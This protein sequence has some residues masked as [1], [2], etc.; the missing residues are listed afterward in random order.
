MMLIVLSWIYFQFTYEI[1]FSHV[2]FII[3][4]AKY[5]CKLSQNIFSQVCLSYMHPLWFR[6]IIKL[7]MII[8]FGQMQTNLINIYESNF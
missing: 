8:L 3:V 6:N 5:M 2:I 4:K 1:I 7:L